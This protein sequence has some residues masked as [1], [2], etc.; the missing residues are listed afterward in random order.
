MARLLHQII[1]VRITTVREKILLIEYPVYKILMGARTVE[2]NPK[3]K[4][5]ARLGFHYYMDS[6]HY[7]NSDLLTW[8]PVLKSLGANWLTLQAP[9]NR[10]IPESFITGLLS[11]GVEPILWFRPSISPQQ[12]QAPQEYQPDWPLLFESYARWGVR[13][14]LLFDRPNLRRSWSARAWVQSELVESFLDTFLPIAESAIQAGLT[15]VFPPLEPGGDYWDLAFLRDCLK[16]IQRRGSKRVLNSL[17]ISAHA[18][19]MPGQLNWGMGGPERWPE[20]R[21]YTPQADQ[22]DQ[23]GFYVFE[24]YQAIVR[25]VLGQPLPILLFEVGRA[26]AEA[27]KNAISAPDKKLRTNEYLA[28]ARLLADEKHQAQNHEAESTLLNPVPGEVLAANFWL[29]VETQDG[30]HSEQAWFKPDGRQEPI[31]AALCAWQ[32]TRHPDEPVKQPVPETQGKSIA[33][34]LLLPKNSSADFLADIRSFVAQHH[35]TIGFSLREASKAVKVSIFGGRDAFPASELDELE[36]A[37]CQVELLMPLGM[38]FA[39]N[40]H[41][42]NP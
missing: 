28:V 1:Y 25:A 2:S 21:P 3:S 22:Q 19:F 37:G 13:F 8:L 16:S 40:R 24:W 15:P 18:H 14:V 11:N 23:R 41:E 4:H 6:L 31:V 12:S 29:L 30:A 20:A 42:V 10:M 34:Y 5:S 9:L 36:K 38:D 7:R 17:H 33:H 35:P 27:E 32:A 39:T 26:E